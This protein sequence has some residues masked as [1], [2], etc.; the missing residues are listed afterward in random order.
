[1]TYRSAAPAQHTPQEPAMVRH[2]RATGPSGSSRAQTVS[3]ASAIPI[4][5]QAKKR[6]SQRPSSGWCSGTNIAVV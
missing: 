2:R 6:G 5:N 1:M 4:A 3:T